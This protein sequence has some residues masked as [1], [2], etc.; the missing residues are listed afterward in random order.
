[1]VVTSI[2]QL[3]GFYNNLLF[4]FLKITLE[5][6]KIFSPVLKRNQ[7]KKPLMQ[8]FF[9]KPHFGGFHKMID[10]QKAVL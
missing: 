6:E 5:F 10:W 3:S 8:A 2:G 4:Q 9:K 1:V 7:N